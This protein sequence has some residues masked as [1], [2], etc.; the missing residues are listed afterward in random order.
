MDPSNAHHYYRARAHFP[1]TPSTPSTGSRRSSRCP[2]WRSPRAVALCLFVVLTSYSGFARAENEVEH[3][4]TLGLTGVY[5]SGYDRGLHYGLAYEL[6]WSVLRVST[7][8]ALGD[9]DPR[10]EQRYGLGVGVEPWSGFRFDVGFLHRSYPDVG[11]GDNLV[12]F[13]CTLHWRGLEIAAGYVM[14]FP[15]TDRDSIHNPFVYDRALFEHYLTFRIGYLYE[16][17]NG[18]G[19]GFLVGTHSRFEQRNLDYPQFSLVVSYEHERVGRFRLD[20]GIGT[21]GFFNQ[22]S[23]IDRGFIRLEYVRS[24]PS[25]AA[26]SLNDDHVEQEGGDDD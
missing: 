20:G 9:T 12:T 5:D 10:S 14:K 1:S 6:A 13:I 3:E 8:L 21:A 17:S 23:T 26:S 18:I 4:I 19:V 22:G 15:I 24:L 11:F 16:F 7:H 2:L 25:R